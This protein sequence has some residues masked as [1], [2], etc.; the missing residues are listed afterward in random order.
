MYIFDHV[1]IL[2]LY[3]SIST[4]NT[5]HRNTLFIVFTTVHASFYEN[6]AKESIIL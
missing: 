6:S 1:H 3:C 4:W 2:L 5:E